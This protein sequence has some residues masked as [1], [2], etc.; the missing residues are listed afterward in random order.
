MIDASSHHGVGFHPN[1]PGTS[2]PHGLC[3]R[4]DSYYGVTKVV[5]EALGSLY[6]D[7]YGLDVV[8]LR[9][10]SYRAVPT[11]ERAGWNW[12]APRDCA[13][14]VEA[15][16]AT[17]SP[18]FRVVWGVSANARRIASLEG[19]LALGYEP[20]DDAEDYLELGSH[21]VVDDTGR[22]G[23]VFTTVDFDDPPYKT[24]T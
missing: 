10:G 7:R 24:A 13:R 22:I 23:G 14:L 9:I 6:H 15:A 16:L 17:P 5:G 18:G 8:C 19:S 20:L 12:L 1:T 2:V 11:D 3:P 4:P 21:D